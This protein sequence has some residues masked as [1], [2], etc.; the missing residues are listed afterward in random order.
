MP[1]LTLIARSGC[2]SVHDVQVLLPNERDFFVFSA[3]H[4]IDS[5]LFGLALRLAEK[6]FFS[7]SVALALQKFFVY[8]SF[9]ESAGRFAQLFSKMHDLLLLLQLLHRQIRFPCNLIFLCSAFVILRLVYDIAQHSKFLLEFSYLLLELD[10]LCLPELFALSVFS[11]GVEQTLHK[12]CLLCTLCIYSLLELVHRTQ[13]ALHFGFPRLDILLLLIICF[14]KR[15]VEPR[16]AAQLLI[17]TQEL[18]LP[19]KSLAL[20]SFQLFAHCTLLLRE[21]VQLHFLGEQRLLR[22]GNLV[23]QTLHARHGITKE[24]HAALELFGGLLQTLGERCDLDLQQF[25]LR[26]FVAQLLTQE[27]QLAYKL[28]VLAILVVIEGCFSWFTAVSTCARTIERLLI[29]QHSTHM[30]TH[31]ISNH[32]ARS[33]ARICE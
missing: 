26:F 25:I 17:D 15:V 24:R 5:P 18:L 21:I 28:F 14:L 13:G 7:K 19:V 1:P 27:A 16:R 4:L 20:L 12:I 10:V 30:I 31:N 29:T 9:L 2:V 3:N 6:K 11:L 32:A 22:L 23:L 8:L 33:F